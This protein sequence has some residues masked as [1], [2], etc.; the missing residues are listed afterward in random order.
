MRQSNTQLNNSQL[1]TKE[2]ADFSKKEMC[3]SVLRYLGIHCSPARTLKRHLRKIYWDELKPKL[4]HHSLA[5]NQID[6]ECKHV[7]K[8]N[9]KENAKKVSMR[10]CRQGRLWTTRRLTQRIGH[11]NANAPLPC[12]VSRQTCLESPL[13]RQANAL[14]KESVA[15]NSAQMS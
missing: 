1:T 13:H 12:L 3:R 6:S 4:I 11:M 10:P 7:N 15:I 9:E 14:V 8:E 2:I 5:L